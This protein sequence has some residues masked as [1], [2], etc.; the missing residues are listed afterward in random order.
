MPLAAGEAWIGY[1]S[2]DGNGGGGAGFR[3]FLN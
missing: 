1:E 2:I 3:Y